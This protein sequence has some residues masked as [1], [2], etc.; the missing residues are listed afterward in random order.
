MCLINFC[1]QPNDRY[2][3]VMAAN[4]DESFVRPTQQ[5]HYWQDAPRILAGRDLEKMG[6]WLGVTT[7]GRIA[8][9]TNFRDPSE[10]IE[11]KRSRGEI[12]RSFLADSQPPEIFMTQLQQQSNQYPGFNVLA[13]TA[14]EL[15]Y[16]SNKKAGIETV[17][18]GTHSLSNAFLNTPWPKSEKG[19]AYLEQCLHHSSTLDPECLFSFLQDDEWALDEALP[20]TGV[21]LEWERKL[22]PLFINSEHYGTRSSTVLII[23]R[24]NHVTFA[25]RTYL[26]GKL[27]GEK[28]FQFQ[29]EPK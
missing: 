25:E 24:T 20:K 17:L 8:A 27:V 6:T 13:G 21:P 18:P 2:K 26:Q 12:I 3:L 29:I 16:Y 7:S 15:W 28:N 10:K 5:A 1:F 11:G 4:R 23:D 19:K 9:L 22:S 14:D